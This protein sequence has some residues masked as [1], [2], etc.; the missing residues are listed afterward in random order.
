[1]VVIHQ[2]NLVSAAVGTKSAFPAAWAAAGAVLAA[3]WGNVSL[4]KRRFR[5]P[6]RAGLH[7]KVSDEARP[8]FN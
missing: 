4:L 8:Y 1:L 2:R 3:I 5:R 7:S 6:C